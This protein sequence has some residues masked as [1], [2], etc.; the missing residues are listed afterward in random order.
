MLGS[1]LSA[2]LMKEFVVLKYKR[3]ILSN[4]LFDALCKTIEG[5]SYL[6]VLSLVYTCTRGWVNDI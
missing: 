6:N 3:F 5:L 1:F 4:N 2:S